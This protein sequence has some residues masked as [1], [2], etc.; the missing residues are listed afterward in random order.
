MELL[1]NN[2]IGD[3]WH[4]FASKIAL[5]TKNTLVYFFNASQGISFTFG[6]HVEAQKCVFIL[7]LYFSELE[8][9]SLRRRWQSSQ[10]LGFI[11]PYFLRSVGWQVRIR[12]VSGDLI[13]YSNGMNTVKT[14]YVKKAIILKFWLY[15][16]KL[17]IHTCLLVRLNHIFKIKEPLWAHKEKINLH[18]TAIFHCQ[19]VYNI[20]F[21]SH[22]ASKPPQ[23]LLRPIDSN[24]NYIRH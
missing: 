8:T 15:K 1:S 14:L 2:R 7:E 17:K 11:L 9:W 6:K 19:H 3:S 18:S 4:K 16:T 12:L 23:Q 20:G 13:S 10:S 24:R 22:N 5:D 21:K